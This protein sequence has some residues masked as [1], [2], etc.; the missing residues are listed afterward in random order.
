MSAS[1]KRLTRGLLAAGLA[2]SMLT[3]APVASSSFTIAKQQ[4]GVTVIHKNG[5]TPEWVAQAL[6]RAK[7]GEW[8]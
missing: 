6:I 7:G 2:L 1:F 3:L 8:I 5:G 4:G